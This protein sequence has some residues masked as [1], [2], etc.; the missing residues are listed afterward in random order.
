M[1]K[2]GAGIDMTH[3]PYKSGAAAVTAIL[4]GDVQ[5]CFVGL[6][7]ALP[8]IKA[9]RVRALAVTTAARFPTTP[10]IPTAQEAELAGF[11]AD[12]WH[13]IFGPARIPNAQVHI[14]PRSLHGFLAERPESLNIILDFLRSH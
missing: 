13:V 11:E 5:L 1:L 6:P 10:D 14:I 7:P 12:N 4:T 2:Q 9:E 3:V 8:H